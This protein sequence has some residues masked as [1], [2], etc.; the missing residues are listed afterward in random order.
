M[1]KASLPRL[2]AASNLMK[3]VDDLDWVVGFS[4]RSYGVRVGIRSNNAAALASACEHLPAEWERVA[5]PVVDRVYSIMIGNKNSS[6]RGRKLNQLYGDDVRLARTSDLGSMF[7]T[8]ESDL[9]LF[10]AE[11]ATHRVFVH[12]GVVGWKGQAIVIPGRSY[13]GKST[14]V[15][16]LVRAGATYY[17]D[18]YA[19]LDSRGRVH[20]FSKP[21]ELREE[22]KFA[23][24]KI[25]VAELGG[26]SGIK[27]LPVR[28]VLMTQFKNGARWRPRKL[29]AGRGVLEM[30]FNTVSARRSPER[31]LATL[32]RVAAQADVL[33]GVRGN[34]SDLID[35]LLRR[36][37][38]RS[39]R[40]R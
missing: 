10:V 3:E 36:V 12:A 38:S 4:L 35:A 25:T 28:L 32:Q 24:T 8:L 23:Q 11:L 40:Q 17:S 14:L 9:R 30:L 1:T 5:S 20:P 7:E 31:A 33:K 13:S 26:Q 18:E 37:E 2:K 6:A 15:A 27:P 34:A 19:V 16:E 22:G 39:N 29:T 21:L